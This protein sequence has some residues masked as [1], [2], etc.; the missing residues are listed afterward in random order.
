M[1]NVRNWACVGKKPIPDGT[2]VG[3]E[4]PS[5][6]ACLDCHFRLALVHHFLQTQVLE[7]Y[8]SSNGH[9]A[10]THGEVLEQ[11]VHDD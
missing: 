3:E 4:D 9:Q 11:H 6:A 1:I 2:G 10:R 5:N 8:F 7:T